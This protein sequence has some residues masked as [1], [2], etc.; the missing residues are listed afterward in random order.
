MG[1]N[2]QT[3]GGSLI[4]TMSADTALSLPTTGTLATLAGV[5]ALTHKSIDAD[6]NTL[7]NIRNTNVASDAAIAYSKLNLA[8]S[9]V[10]ADLSGS[11]AV[12]YSALILT[13]SIV[14][15]DV[16]SAAGIS[17]SKLNLTGSVLNAD[18]SAS[19][20]IA[21]SKLNLSG[22]VA[23]ADI[24]SSAA[25]AGSKI[26]P[27][28][29]N[30]AITGN[31][32]EF[33][34]G[35]NT[36][37]L[38]PSGSQ[39]GNIALILP[40]DAPTAGQV[41][42]ANA[43][44]TTQ[45]EWATAGGGT[46][47]SVGLSMPAEFSVAGTPVT[48]SGTLA[49]T[50]ANQIS[51]VVFAGP[52]TGSAA[53]PTFRALVVADIPSGVDHGNLSGLS[54]DDHTQYHNDSRAL[55]WLGTRSTLD[56]PENTN[57]YY[58]AARFDTAFS[59]KST[60]DLS[61]GSKLYFTD[62]RAQDAVGGALTDS[63]SVDFTYNDA[64][65][66]ISAAVLPAGVDHDSLLNYSA[67]KHVDHTAVTIS[68]ASN[69][70][71]SGGGTLAA[72]RT[73]SVDPTNATS[74]SI[75]TGDIILFADISAANA[76]KQTT[77]S[78]LL[79]LGGGSFAA[80]WTSGTTKTVTHSLSSRDVIVQLYDN[81]TYETIEVDTVIRTDTNTVDL[82]ASAAPSGSGWRVLIKKI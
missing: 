76:L 82:T 30:Q 21:Y 63:S 37:G 24:S 45:L 12:P 74:A 75:A 54:D 78:D 60:T 69:G 19:A 59:A 33:T 51:N 47:S 23:N 25:I 22:S 56:L 5:E 38:T 20:Q 9:I 16:A 7:T 43:L 44:D 57:L 50:K 41:L 31:S 1:G 32:I 6:L 42:R 39:S 29:G 17:Y 68:G 40:T 58:T 3:I 14:N 65:G 66:T 49:V 10:A 73:L 13:N 8:G 77:V 61:E 27:Q 34:N 46:V 62:E 80:D 2:L 48:G 64:G 79:S 71:L 11:A 18:I 55:T 67:N 52:A 70:G 81:T 36:F 72:S 26:A 28:F 15:A 35:T 53:A 4:L